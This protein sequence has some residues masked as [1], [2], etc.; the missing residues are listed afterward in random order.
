MKK[1][2]QSIAIFLGLIL[3]STFASAAGGLQGISTII[4]DV[5]S[6]LQNMG[7]AIVTIAIMWAGYKIV[8]SGAAIRDIVHVLIGAV[9]VGAAASIA[10][11]LLG[12]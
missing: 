11:M 7:L 8:F 12:K 4:D 1:S 2:T 3:L 10:G 5:T 9:L 6:Q